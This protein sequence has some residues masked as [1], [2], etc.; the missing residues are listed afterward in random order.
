ML[1]TKNK[2]KKP[3]YFIP[4]ILQIPQKIQD[5]VEVFYVLKIK[6]I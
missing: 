5:S 6:Q 2:A 3:Q 4:I 1:N